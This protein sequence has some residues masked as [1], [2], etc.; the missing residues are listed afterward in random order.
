MTAAL[1]DIDTCSLCRMLR[2]VTSWYEE[3]VEL[4]QSVGLIEGWDDVGLYVTQAL[5]HQ[6][7][8]VGLAKAFSQPLNK[9]LR[10]ELLDCA[11]LTLVLGATPLMA[12]VPYLGLSS[13]WNL[14]LCPSL[15]VLFSIIRDIMVLDGR[16]NRI[17]L[18]FITKFWGLPETGVFILR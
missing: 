2:Y 8:T 16:F 10:S 12:L 15:K 5:S 18:F 4:T 6:E 11:A 14:D 13:C 17:L 3:S 9:T 7:E 1:K